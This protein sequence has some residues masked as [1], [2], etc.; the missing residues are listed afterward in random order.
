LQS[1][2]QPPFLGTVLELDGLHSEQ[3]IR[4]GAEHARKATEK[5]ANWKL[6]GKS[7]YVKRDKQPLGSYARHYYEL[8]QLSEQREVGTCFGQTNLGSYARHYY[9]LSQLSEQREVGTCF[10][11]TTPRSRLITTRSVERISREAISSQ[12]A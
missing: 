11:Q 10:G 9:E 8:S 12:K 5:D 2:P 7:G 4:G 3:F 1:L 6:K